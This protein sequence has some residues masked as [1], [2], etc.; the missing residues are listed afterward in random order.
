MRVVPRLRGTGLLLLGALAASGCSAL[1]SERQPVGSSF[2]GRQYYER[3]RIAWAAG[4]EENARFLI[5]RAVE[6]DPRSEA[7]AFWQ[8]RWPVDSLPPAAL[9]AVLGNGEAAAAGAEAEAEP[10]AEPG[11]RERQA[12]TG[13]PPGADESPALAD[14]PSDEPET[15]LGPSREPAPEPEAPREPAPEPEAAREP[16]TVPPE[17]VAELRTAFERARSS[18]DRQGILR[19]GEA[20]LAAQP[21]HL[22]TVYRVLSVWVEDRLDPGRAESQLRDVLA[23]LEFGDPAYLAGQPDDVSDRTYLRAYR[24]RF[25]D[26][27]GWSAFQ[28]GDMA[29]AEAALL[30]AEREIN[31]RGAG[32]VSNLRHLA[33]FYERRGDLAQ[34]LSYAIAAAARDESG[35]GE[36]RALASRL[37]SRR[38]GGTAGLDARLAQER[39]RA[40]REERAAAIAG[41]LYAP[42]PIFDARQVGGGVVTDESLRGAVT[43]LVLWTPDCEACVRL[44]R[45]LAAEGLAGGA[46]ARAP[47]EI[48]ALAMG[49]DVSRAGAALQGAP[50]LEVAVVEQPGP[51]ARALDAE[52]LPVTLVIEPAGFIQYRHTGYPDETTA[53]ERWL[54]RLRWQVESLAGLVAGPTAP[55]GSRRPAS[56]AR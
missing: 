47:V 54:Q 32:D 31:L 55:G 18:G 19:G 14:A 53:R 27:L 49:G 36:V 26:L 33:G 50:G 13:E 46:A 11:E 40:R 20:L 16:P 4:N 10:R 7:L 45:D 52:R 42:I 48:V 21:Y 37:W 12:E 38:Q 34:A 9:A 8:A 2:L 5:G 15:A 29:Q 22:P 6:L 30:S 28:R 41:R 3:G 51:L 44:L 43:L 17:E 23:S 39:E 24:G 25:L 56:S 1:R 35:S